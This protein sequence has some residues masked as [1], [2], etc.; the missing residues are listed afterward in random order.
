MPAQSLDGLVFAPLDRPEH[1][2]VDAATR[3]AYHEADGV[4]WAEY[5][6]GDI[7]RGHLVGTRDGDRLDF[8][9]VQL[10]RAGGTASGH[11]VSVVVVLADGRLRLDETWEW[12]SRD[13]KGTSAVEQIATS[14]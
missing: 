3:F 5:R 2:E 12:E 10:N 4:V 7:V 14:A 11:C 6:G 13:G 1:G 9:Y 8:R